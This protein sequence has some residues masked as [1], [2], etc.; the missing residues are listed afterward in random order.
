MMGV[1]NRK[2]TFQMKCG[3]T[4]TEI[5]VAVVVVALIA[6]MALPGF[7]TFIKKM[8][9]QEANGILPTLL[10]YQ[11][12]YYKD[13]GSY[14]NSMAKLDVQVPAPKNFK[15][16]N[17]TDSTFFCAGK[18][19]EAVAYMEYND[20]TFNLAVTTEGDILCIKSCTSNSCDSSAPNF[21]LNLG[22]LTCG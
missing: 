16:I 12:A 13:N 22:Y 7:G 11:M 15:Q 4:L 21:C 5:M 1:M 2:R 20:S 14:A 10:N 8:K 18:N 19:R 3:Y 17:L 6:G 9:C